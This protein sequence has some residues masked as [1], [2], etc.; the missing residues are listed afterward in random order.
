MRQSETT[1][2]VALD[3]LKAANL[4]S[5]SHIADITRLAPLDRQ[6]W[7]E[8]QRLTAERKT[9]SGQLDRLE[10]ERARGETERAERVLRL[11]IWWDEAR[12]EAG[13]VAQRSG[14]GKVRVE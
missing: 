2:W 14:K 8:L 9:C 7:T 12:R 10:G 4:A 11:M 6:M 1:L 3:K 5:D 13:E